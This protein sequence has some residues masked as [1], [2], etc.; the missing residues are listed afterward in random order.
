[1]NEEVGG[2][3]VASLSGAN[4][5]MLFYML[6]HDMLPCDL[7]DPGMTLREVQQRLARIGIDRTLHGLNRD[8]QAL[9]SV[10]RVHYDDEKAV[11]RRYYRLYPD[12]LIDCLPQSF[13]RAAA[14]ALV[15]R[16]PDL[17]SN[18]LIARRNTGLQ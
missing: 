9:M 10:A 14:P 5:K 3:F 8:I 18:I 11:P 1:M 2:D 17:P 13:R 7:E 15:P 16:I 6:I 12:R 4:R